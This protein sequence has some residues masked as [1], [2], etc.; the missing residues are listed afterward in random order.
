[1]NDAPP[2]PAP[3]PA[4]KAPEKPK[5]ADFKDWAL[6][7]GGTIIGGLGTATVMAVIGSAVLW[8]RFREAGL[9]AAQAVAV[10]PKQEALVQGAQ[11]TIVFVLLA[12]A[13]VGALYVL[14]CR[15]TPGETQ[16]ADPHAIHKGAYVV[17]ILLSIAG[18]AWAMLATDLGTGAVVELGLAAVV[19]CAGCLWMGRNNEKNFWALAGVVFVA[20]IVF[21]GIAE[22]LIVKEQKYVQ[23]VAVLRDE[24][25]HGVTG[26]YVAATEKK[27]YFANAIR[28]TP[29]QPDRKPMQEVA[30]HE[31][32]TYAIGPLEPQADAALRAQAMLKRLVADREA[33]PAPPKAEEH[34]QAP[35][36]EAESAGR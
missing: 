3:V 34:H 9:P 12:V 27:L 19:L 18:I 26:F 11:V 10:Q 7:T 31:D 24:N 8:V 29:T 2:T 23:A 1:M 32:S 13:I 4:A 33:N 36:S 30:L 17:L 6:K 16:P 14:D 15:E 25:D 28:E 22:F 21:A 20:V 5:K 35:P